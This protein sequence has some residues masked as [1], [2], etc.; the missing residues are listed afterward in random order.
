MKNIGLIALVGGWVILSTW[1]AYV[2]FM[3]VESITYK[4]SIILIWSGILLLLIRAIQERVRES[5]T[6]PYKDIER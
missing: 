5:K 3:E 1:G 2:G 4:I 6:D